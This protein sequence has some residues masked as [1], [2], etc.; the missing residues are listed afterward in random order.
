MASVG[1]GSTPHVVGELFKSMAGVNLVHVPYRTSPFPDLLGGQGGTRHCFPKYAHGIGLF[2]TPASPR[3]NR[4]ATGK[5]HAEAIG[6]G[7][8]ALPGSPPGHSSP[9]VAFCGALE[10]PSWGA[11]GL[12]LCPPVD[13]SDRPTTWAGK[14]I[15]QFKRQKGRPHRA[16]LSLWA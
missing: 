1:T 10:G 8:E 11:L 6:K 3:D 13:K 15:C 4:E 12:A 2:V 16:A 9:W 14:S 7:Q 5:H